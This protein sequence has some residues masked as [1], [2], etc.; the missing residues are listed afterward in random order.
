MKERVEKGWGR[1]RLGEMKGE[2]WFWTIAKGPIT[3]KIKHAH[4]T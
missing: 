1:K 3:S 2:P 4:K